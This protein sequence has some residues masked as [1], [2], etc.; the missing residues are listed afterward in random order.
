MSE[1]V[2]ILAFLFDWL[3]VAKCE[4]PTVGK[5]RDGGI[6]GLKEEC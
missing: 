5:I 2:E 1:T 3:N 6:F 4:I